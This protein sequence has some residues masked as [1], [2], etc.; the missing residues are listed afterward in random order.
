MRLANKWM[1][2]SFLLATALPMWASQFYVSPAGSSSGDGSINRPWD[3]ATA[4]QGPASV[5]PGDTIWLRAGTY[6]GQFTST[7]S[8]TSAAPIIVRQY[9]SERAT[10]DGGSSRTAALTVSGSYC[11]FWGF[12]IM[13]SDPIRV[14]P[15]PGPWP[16]E[17]QRADGVVAGF[18][19]QQGVKFINLVIHDAS[20]GYSFWSGAENSEIY[21]SVVYNNGWQGSDGGHGHSVYSQNQTGVKQII[22]NIMF[23]SYSFGIQIYGSSNAYLNNYDIEGN[24]LFDHGSLASSGPKANI[25]ISG[26]NVAQNPI[27]LNNYTYG[28]SG[29]RGIDMLNDGNGCNAPT[30]NNNYLAQGT[31]GS[32]LVINCSNILSITGNTLYGA[33]NISTSQYPNNTYLSTPSGVQVFVRPN[34]YEAGR[35]NITIYNWANQASVTVDLS[36]SGLAL[37][38]PFE[39]R[40]A[41]NFFGAPVLQGIYNGGSVSIPMTN[42]TAAQPIGN[43]AIPAVHTAPRFGAF[44]VLPRASVQNSAPSVAAGSN[45]TVEFPLKV[46]L[47][48]TATD[49]GLP[50]GTLNIAWTQVSGPGTT[51]FGNAASAATTA[52]FSVPGV[53]VLKLAASDGALSSSATTTVTVNSAVDGGGTAIRV[54]AGGPAYTDPVGILWSADTGYSG[55][56][57]YSTA[58]GIGSTYSPVLYQ[59]SRYST[60][61]LSYQFAVPNGTYTVNLKFAEPYFTTPGKRVFNANINGQPQLTNFDIVSAAGGPYKAIDRSFTIST[62]TNQIAIDLIPLVQYPLICGIEIIEQSGTGTG[63]APPPPSSSSILVNAGGGAYTD[64]Q[65]RAWSAD[66]GSLGGNVFS[67][68]SNI[69]NTSDP[70]LYKTERWAAGTLSYRFA[71]PNGTYNLTLKFAEIYFTNKGQRVFN[72]NVNGQTVQANFDPFAAAGAANTAVDKQFPV[73]VTN[74]Q[75]AIDLVA[76]V[77]NPTLSGVEIDLQGTAPTAPTTSF[78]P[79]LVRAGTPDYT[80]LQGNTWKADFGYSGGS[81][82]TASAPPAN[83]QSPALYQTARYSAAPFQYNFSVPNGNHTVTLKFVELYFTT[84]NSRLFNVSI[85]GQQVLT[86]FDIVGAAGGAGIPA[87]QRFAVNVANGQ[88]TIVLTPVTQNPLINGI[89][90]D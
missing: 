71:V 60:G 27:L 39:I 5:Q 74:G 23:D 11:W 57:S 44:V 80:D 34:Q 79:I 25:L 48:G 83:T 35:S 40:D 41:E 55:G 82:W 20:Q 8:G 14:V 49:D 52:S 77:E 62:T 84:R 22:D 16:S 56:S 85:N 21:G 12:E 18:V 73:S 87:D 65:G 90:I 17:L 54:N 15:S 50:N 10:I 26:G 7:L 47:N 13:Y 46:V 76:V 53:Y 67:T 66:M 42:L 6:P 58:S 31:G 63:T 89:R 81:L 2:V 38:T 30:I 88:I 33:T 43:Y 86:N 19:G 64:S 4:L 36:R 61:K 1:P 69:A 68:S 78:Q 9:P 24:T 70:T 72:I 75:I 28:L 59:T 29:G 37:N 51:T 3:L 45:Q 32:S